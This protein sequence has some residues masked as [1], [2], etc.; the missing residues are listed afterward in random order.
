MPIVAAVAC[1]PVV[2]LPVVGVLVVYLPVVY[3]PVVGVVVV[4]LPVVYL[5]AVGVVVV[6]L[7]VVYLV[8]VDLVDGVSAIDFTVLCACVVITDAVLTAKDIFIK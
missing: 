2:Y 8:F 7:P 5:P 3:L 6:H 1:L 4:Y